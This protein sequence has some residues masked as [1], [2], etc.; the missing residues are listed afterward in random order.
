MNEQDTSKMYEPGSKLLELEYEHATQ[1]LFNVDDIRNRL[2]QFY[3]L[4]TGIVVTVSQIPGIASQLVAGLSF[5]AF[6]FG[7]ILVATLARLRMIV[8][9]SYRAQT[10]IRQY[11]IKHHPEHYRQDLRNALLWDEPSVPRKERVLSYSFLSSLSVIFLNS[12]VLGVALCTGLQLLVAAVGM[13]VLACALQI[14]IYLAV[15]KRE[16]SRSSQTER[17]QEK[18]AAL[19]S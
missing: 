19:M 15:L 17:Y 18:I 2:F 9:A 8:I 6:I 12:I 1:N 7:V 10:L 3:V 16:M 11:Y 5:L 14:W 13:P 4:V